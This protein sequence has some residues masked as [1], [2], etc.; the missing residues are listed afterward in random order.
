MHTILISPLTFFKPNTHYVLYFHPSIQ[1]NYN[2]NS[3]KRGYFFSWKTD[4]LLEG[5]PPFLL[6]DKEGEESSDHSLELDHKINEFVYFMDQRCGCHF[7][8]E[9]SHFIFSNQTELSLLELT[10]LTGLSNPEYKLIDLFS[11]ESSLIFLKTLPL[12]PLR[13]PLYSHDEFT[14][15]EERLWLE[16]LILFLD[17]DL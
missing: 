15:I 17:F 7:D 6:F 12:F 5:S 2:Q 8:L 16:Q 4:H 14:S 1:L 9:K 10:Y 13:G 11:P 3:E